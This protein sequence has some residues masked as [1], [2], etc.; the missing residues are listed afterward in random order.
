MMFRTFVQ[1][2]SRKQVKIQVPQRP[3]I[4]MGCAARELFIRAIV[5]R[6]NLRDKGD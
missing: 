6:W 1:N 3:P 5:I 4:E 2:F